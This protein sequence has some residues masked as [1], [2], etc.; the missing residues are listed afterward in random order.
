[1]ELPNADSTTEPF[2]FR[3]IQALYLMENAVRLFY[4]RFQ[5]TAVQ[6]I[7]NPNSFTVSLFGDN[8]SRGLAPTVLSSTIGN[9]LWFN[10]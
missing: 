6:L 1:M 5:G 7:M 4:A 9:S 3:P 10:A 2:V 8:G